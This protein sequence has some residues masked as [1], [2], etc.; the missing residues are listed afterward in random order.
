[1]KIYI[2]KTTDPFFNI[3]T[4]EYFLKNY[5]EEM[6]LLYRN[7][8][9]IIVGKH[10]NAL[11]EI[12][13][14]FAIE[15]NIPVVRRISGGGT[16]FHDLGNLNF[17]FILNVGKSPVNFRKY[18]GP[19]VE[20][21][22]TLGISAHFNDRNNIFINDYK[23]SGN[24][25]HIFKKRVLHHGTL[26]FNS[27]LDRLNQSIEVHPERYQS[28]AIQ[29]VR[30]NVAN[31][32]DYLEEKI[33]FISFK[34]KLATFLSQK[35]NA[36]VFHLDDDDIANIYSLIREKYSTKQ[37]NFGYSPKYWFLNSFYFQGTKVKLKFYVLKGL[38]EK[39]EIA[40]QPQSNKLEKVFRNLIN[41]WHYPVDFK[42]VLSDFFE[43][44]E[45]E[46]LL[47]ELF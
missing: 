38:I 19:I 25:E 27:N 18:A 42:A 1:M 23:V 26:L 8:A 24:A 10:Q 13:H 34:K 9:S 12:N 15:N 36:E 20:F 14:S 16:V 46:I 45:Q 32:S 21:L 4:E 41:N 31:I 11:A 17:S 2:S 40:T 30:K 39:I 47:Q 37:W 5:S 28:K 22:E 7:K 43:K 44:E 3:A 6:I 33:N 29:S 35:L